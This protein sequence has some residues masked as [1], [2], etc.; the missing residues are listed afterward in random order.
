MTK[1]ESTEHALKMIKEIAF[2]TVDG[3]VKAMKTL[4]DMIGDDR[5]D[6][7]LVVNA[8]A[9][10]FEECQKIQPKEG[11]EA[12]CGELNKEAGA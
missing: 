2:H 1:T 5:Y 12:W 4:D 3:C 7:T 10:A 8:R 9:L 6:Q 11:Q